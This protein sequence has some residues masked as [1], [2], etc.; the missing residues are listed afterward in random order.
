MGCRM[1]G[2]GSL[3]EFWDNIKAGRSAIT[4]VP[5]S[6]GIRRSTGIRTARSRTR[7]TPRSAGSSRLHVQ[8]AALPHSA[9]VA[10]TVD[11]VQQ[12]ALEAVADAL[13]DAGYGD[14]RD[15]DPHARR[16]H[17]RQL[18]GR[19]QLGTDYEIR[20]HYP[21]MRKALQEVP[22]FAGVAAPVQAGIL[23]VFETKVKQDLTPIT[24]DSMP[25]EL[26][27]RDRGTRR[28]RLQPRGSETSPST[29]RARARSPRSR[30]R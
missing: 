23:G 25:G 27:E 14:K 1:P 13:D 16:R 4:E 8:P 22:D 24:E 11:P 29:P 5:S 2:A 30:P 19:E 12:V 26:V 6:A 7:P 3:A 9:A 21:A 18:D 28:E 15:F 17:P 10:K 20:V